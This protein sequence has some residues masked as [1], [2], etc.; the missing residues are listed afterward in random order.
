MWDL[1]TKYSN[2]ISPKKTSQ[3]PPDSEYMKNLCRKYIDRRI[4]V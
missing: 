3:F 4:D 2:M 1:Y